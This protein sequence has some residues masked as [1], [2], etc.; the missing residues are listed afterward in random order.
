PPA[1]VVE[2]RLGARGAVARV[3]GVAGDRAQAAVQVALGARGEAGHGGAVR[4]GRGCGRDR[5][6]RLEQRDDVP[7]RR[8]RVAVAVAE[9][10]VVPAEA[11]VA[12]AGARER[13]AAFGQREVV[14]LGAARGRGRGR[15]GGGGRARRGGAA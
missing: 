10:R 14:L 1:V 11:P 7:D 13:D 2:P 6:D 4:G 8:Q 12:P 9:P 3:G 5:V 15:G